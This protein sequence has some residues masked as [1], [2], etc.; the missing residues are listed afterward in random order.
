[1]KYDQGSR[2]TCGIGSLVCVG[3]KMN[4]RGL[5]ML[6]LYVSLG[7]MTPAASAP[8]VPQQRPTVSHRREPT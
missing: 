5:E 2:V 8:T 3:E 1:V 4:M 6:P 7:I